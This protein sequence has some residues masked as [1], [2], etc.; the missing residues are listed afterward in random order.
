[1][2]HFLEKNPFFFTVFLF[3]VIAYAGLI[4]ILPGFSQAARPV[5]GHKPYTA[6]ISR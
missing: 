2:F 4:E 5:V 1:M 6:G 3:I